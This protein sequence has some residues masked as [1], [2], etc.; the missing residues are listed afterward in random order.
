MSNQNVFVYKPRRDQA[1]HKSG[2]PNRQ[3]RFPRPGFEFPYLFGKITVE[4]L[5]LR[6]GSR[7]GRLLRS[8]RLQRI[9]PSNPFLVKSALGISFIGAAKGP[10]AV[11]Q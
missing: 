10:V 11:G 9:R 3:D 1:P 5:R 8:C 2:T 4:N 7:G 6:P